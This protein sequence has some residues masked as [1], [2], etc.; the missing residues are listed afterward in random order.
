MGPDCRD[1]VSQRWRAPP[2]FRP[3]RPTDQL[4][5]RCATPRESHLSAVDH[6]TGGVSRCSPRL[7]PLHQNRRAFTIGKVPGDFLDL[8]VR[9]R[10]PR[11]AGLTHVLDKGLPLDQV[12]GLLRVYTPY[13]DIWK[14]GWGTAYLDPAVVEKI[15]LLRDADV[16]ACT[17][18]TLLELSWVQ[19]RHADCLAWAADSGFACV[20][21]SNGVVAM[22]QEENRPGRGRGTPLHRPHRGRVEG[23]RRG[24]V[25]SALGG[26]GD[27]GPGG[28]GDLGGR[29]GREAGS[30]G[31]YEPDG[32]VRAELVAAL[33]AAVGVERLIFEAPLRSQQAWLIR[34]FGPDV[35]LGNIAPGE[36]LGVE[37]LRLGLRADTMTRSGGS[38]GRC[39][40]EPDAGPLPEVSVTVVDSRLTAAAVRRHLLGREVY[41]RTRFVVLRSGSDTAL[42]AVTKLDDVRLFAPVVD[43]AVLAL[44]EK[45]WVD[46]PEV[47]RGAQP[48][49][50][51]APV[52]TPLVS[53]V[54]SWPDGT[55]M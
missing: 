16:L 41:R 12:R 30:V 50:S 4:V 47:D 42:V 40:E 8:P 28:G 11:T 13:V 29:R 54:P 10:K 17:G 44:P 6:G 48:A 38:P 9:S 5:A 51:D 32:R 53:G 27:P 37:T 31:L 14:F 21:V 22:P 36:V 55:A 7:L 26:T 35:S 46:A 49:G 25:F 43:V 18:G 45:P 39:R 52:S 3:S 33:A 23:S 15:A 19:G 20:E 1:Q 34:E 2:P 24:C